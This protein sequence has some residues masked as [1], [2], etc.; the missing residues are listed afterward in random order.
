MTAFDREG[1]VTCVTSGVP[2]LRFAAVYFTAIMAALLFS[3]PT[4]MTSE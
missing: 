3:P 4:E 2:K 1:E